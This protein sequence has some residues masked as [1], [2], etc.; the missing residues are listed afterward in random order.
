MFESWYVCVFNKNG[1][2]EYVLLL[3][4]NIYIIYNIVIKVCISSYVYD[5]DLYDIY[6]IKGPH[7]TKSSF[8]IIIYIYIIMCYLSNSLYIGSSHQRWKR[9]IGILNDLYLRSDESHFNPW[10]RFLLSLHLVFY[11]SIGNYVFLSET[12]GESP[13]GYILNKRGSWVQYR[14]VNQETK[15]ER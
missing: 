13:T 15:K 8:E 2:R 3:I 5:Y 9:L 7:V 1:W 14:T 11:F 4:M 6:K 12:G 10:T